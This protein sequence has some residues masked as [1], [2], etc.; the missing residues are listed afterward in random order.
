MVQ[1]AHFKYTTTPTPPLALTVQNKFTQHIQVHY[2]GGTSISYRVR[3]TGLAQYTHTH[4]HNTRY[5]H[6]ALSA[7]LHLS[8]AICFNSS[9]QLTRLFIAICFNSS[10]QLLHLSFCYLLQQQPATF[11]PFLCYL[12]Q[13]QPAKLLHVSARTPFYAT[14]LASVRLRTPNLRPFFAR[15]SPEVKDNT[16]ERELDIK[17]TVLHLKHRVQRTSNSS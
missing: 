15:T 9:Q 11:T 14:E 7:A 4:T 5:T 8:S 6:T 12:L 1:P 3:Y 13:Q 16:L 17:F 10:Q 2:N